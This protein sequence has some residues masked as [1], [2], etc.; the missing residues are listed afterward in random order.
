MVVIGA[1]FGGLVVAC[2]LAALGHEVTLFDKRDKLGGRG[3]QYE[4][5]GFKFDGGPTVIT[6]PYLFDEIFSAAGRRWQDY[7]T[8]VPLDPFYRIFNPTGRH[9]DYCRETEANLAS[10]RE[11]NVADQAG[12]QRFLAGTERIFDYFGQFTDK[13]F[14][15]L[16]DMLRILPQMVKLNAMGGTHDFVSKHIKDDFLRQ[17]FSFHPLLIGGNPLDTPSI[18]TLIAQF[19]KRW[20]VL[21]AMGGTG[22]IVRGL[23]KLFGKLGGQA[24]LNTE[25]TAI[26]T[27]GRRVKGVT[28]ANGDRVAADAVVCNGDLA[29]TYRHLI[30]AKVRRTWMNFRIDRL[31]KYSMGL[32][33]IYFGTNRRYDDS[34]LLHYNIIVGPRYKGLLKDVFR[35]G[36]ALP[37]DFALYLHMPTRTDASVAP[38]GCESFY[39]LAP[40]PNLGQVD[41]AAQGQLYRDRIM[42]FLEDTYLPGLRQHIVAE[43][44]IDPTHF[45]TALNS[46]RGA[47][48][49]LQPTLF[50][51]AWLRPHNRA[52]DFDNLYFAGAGTHPGAGIPSVLSLG[53]IAATLIHQA[54]QEKARAFA[55][56]Y[57]PAAR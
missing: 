11:W 57:A 39:V 21:Y 41:W 6:V 45:E 37:Q 19:E 32:F 4:L 56:S 31:T 27:E 53:K 24:H 22:A 38:V 33:V 3:Y 18:Y 7:F 44:R 30:P 23:G 5:N 13:P 50:Q 51:S 43:H 2:R 15:R 8:L 55:V 14:L 35:D 54:A 29:Y 28:L 46:Y 16:A 10:I 34:K 12:Y 49:S 42:Q 26:L 1:G 52:E 40:A 20:G 9:F 47:A 25:V 36:G 17:V 48:F